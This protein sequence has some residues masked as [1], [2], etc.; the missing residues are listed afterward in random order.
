MHP[1]L[2][3]LNSRFPEAVLSVHEDQA[4]SEI[5]ARVAA[6]RIVDVAKFLHDDPTTAFDH[7]TDICSADYPDDAERFE[8]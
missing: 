8:V 1:V 5:S 6:D 3:T 2:E 7:I 4:R